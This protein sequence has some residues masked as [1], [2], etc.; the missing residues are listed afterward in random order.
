MVAS[1]IQLD[2]API[3][4]AI[5]LHSP[6]ASGSVCRSASFA[7]LVCSDYCALTLIQLF[8]QKYSCFSLLDTRK[9]PISIAAGD[10]HPPACE[11]QALANA[12]REGGNTMKPL[13][14][15]S[16]SISRSRAGGAAARPLHRARTARV[17]R[18]TRTKL[19][20]LRIA[21]RA[22]GGGAAGRP[23]QSTS[24]GRCHSSRPADGGHASAR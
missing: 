11:S 13:A 22:P 8:E 14:M 23:G 6:S 19:W 17:S 4:S 1:K 5:I 18:G 2:R 9:V 16:P 24:D 15:F 20:A 3:S 7:R 12:P 21:L 10:G